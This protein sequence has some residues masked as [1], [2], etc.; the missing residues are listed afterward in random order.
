MDIVTI[1]QRLINL[2][3]FMTKAAIARVI[4]AV[5]IA[6]GSGDLQE[7]DGYYIAVQFFDVVL[8][9]S[10]SSWL[11]LRQNQPQVL[12]YVKQMYFPLYRPTHTQGTNGI[13]YFGLFVVAA[14]V[15]FG[16]VGVHEK[17]SPPQIYVLRDAAN[18][19]LKVGFS[20]DFAFRFKK[21][22]L[23]YPFVRVVTV[24]PAKNISVERELHKFLDAH[25][26]PET[27][28]WYSDTIEVREKINR[29][30]LDRGTIKTPDLALEAD[31]PLELRLY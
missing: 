2:D 16:R 7:K 8:G 23:V 25:R 3:L 6:V 11:H 31:A 4:D 9:K 30:M 26:L 1:H 21:L 29:F 15:G 20:R 5:E 28:E 18:K 14:M 27:V 13:T 19:A 22:K 10:R 24:F 17:T 12:N